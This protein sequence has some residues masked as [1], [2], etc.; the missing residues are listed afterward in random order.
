MWRRWM[1]DVME[2]VL[3]DEIQAC[4][5][6]KASRVD[7]PQNHQYAIVIHDASALSS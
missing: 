4:I 2:S 5:K 7:T 1:G 3:E 6:S